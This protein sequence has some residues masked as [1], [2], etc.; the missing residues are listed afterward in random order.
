[1]VPV[2]S[3]SDHNRIVTA[4]ANTIN[5]NGVNP[6]QTRISAL[7]MTKKGENWKKKKDRIAI[8]IAMKIQ[9]M[10]VPK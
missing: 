5:M 3:S 6:N 2:R 7:S 8:C 1:M 10:G 9:A 4:G